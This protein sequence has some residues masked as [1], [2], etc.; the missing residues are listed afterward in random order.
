[1]RVVT[2]LGPDAIGRA[3]PGQDRVGEELV[4]DARAVQQVDA[5]RVKGSVK[6]A[7]IEVL[8]FIEEHHGACR[9]RLASDMDDGDRR[10][11]KALHPGVFQ[12]VRERGVLVKEEKV[13][14]KER[15]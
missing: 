10:Q 6:L 14:V 8:A 7:E 12:G 15:R 4:A 11:Y 9:P 1:M 3:E 13:F 5:F 2:A